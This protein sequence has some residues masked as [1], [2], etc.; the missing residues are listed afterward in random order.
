MSTWPTLWHSTLV[1]KFLMAIT[2]AAMFLFVVAHLVGNLQIFFGPKVLNHYA[3]FLKSN[4]EIIWPA[5]FGVLTCVVLHIWTA[6]RLTIENRVARNHPYGEQKLVNANLASRTMIWTGLVVASFI[7]YHLAHYTLMWMHPE[8]RNLTDAHGDA[9]VYRMLLL[10]FRHPCVVGTY[11]V[12]VGLLC[13]HLSHG[14]SAMF[15][16]LGLKNHVHTERINRVAALVALTLFLGYASI[17]TAVFVG[18]VK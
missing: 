3:Y 16:S 8:Y 2:G 1:K 15:Q 11:I 18:L 7:G 14:I 12:S 5:R 6:I 13:F 9:D 10:G 17:P 4:P